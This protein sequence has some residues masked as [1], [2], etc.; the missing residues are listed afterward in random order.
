ME[1]LNAIL[2]SDKENE[3]SDTKFC[4][5]VYFHGKLE[6]D[7]GYDLVNDSNENIFFSY[8]ENMKEKE[9]K[10]VSLKVKVNE[11]IKIAY[12]YLWKIDNRNRGLICYPDDLE[13]INDAKKKQIELRQFL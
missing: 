5:G 3:L 2:F 1:K 8:L 9:S 11:E 7:L 13:A 6:D 4:S 10:I 12:A